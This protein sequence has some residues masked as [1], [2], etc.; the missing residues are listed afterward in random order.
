MWRGF[1]YVSFEVHKIGTIKVTVSY[2]VTPYNLADIWQRF[3]EILIS[4]I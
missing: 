4:C 2:Y 1:N 3:G